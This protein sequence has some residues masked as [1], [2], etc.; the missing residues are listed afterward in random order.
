MPD[1]NQPDR[2]APV[3]IP[4][5]SLFAAARF[6]IALARQ[7]SGKMKLWLHGAPVACGRISEVNWEE[8]Q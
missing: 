4:P 1:F 2:A 3:R 8:R 5:N 6:A 7:N